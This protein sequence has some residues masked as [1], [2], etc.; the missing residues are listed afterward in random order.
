MATSN[1]KQASS[2]LNSK[3]LL[4]MQ[5]FLELVIFVTQ[6]TSYVVLYYLVTSYLWMSYFHNI[7]INY[8]MAGTTAILLCASVREQ[9]KW[10]QSQLCYSLVVRRRA[11]SLTKLEFSSCKM[12]LMIFIRILGKFNGI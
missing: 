11:S 9:S 2:L 7:I 6:G 12:R 4:F 1:R 5:L 3:Y 10:F 8:W